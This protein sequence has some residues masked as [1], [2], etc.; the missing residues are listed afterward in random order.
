[1]NPKNNKWRHTM[2]QDTKLHYETVSPVLVNALLRIMG[3]NLF[4]PFRLVGGTNLS[5]RYGHRQSDDI[6][7]FTDA[8][9]GS[10]DFDR[11]EHYLKNNFTYY[12]CPDTS[13]IVGFGRSYYIGVNKDNAVKLDLMYTDQFFDAP[14]L[15]DDIRFASADQIAAM[16]MQAIATGG[17]KKDWWD[18][19]FLMGQYSLDLLMQLHSKWQPYT[20]N[21]TQ[22]LE[23]LTD[24]SE[25]NKYPDPICNRHLQWDDIKFDIVDAV[26]AFLNKRNR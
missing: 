20:H 9:Y 1:M 3:E 14:E 4:A 5:L 26:E 10:L 12:D 8:E 11:I 7:L 18:I 13:G 22:L 2:R 25:A 24:F 17:R 6:D 21:E 19:H 15:I 16:K 23:L